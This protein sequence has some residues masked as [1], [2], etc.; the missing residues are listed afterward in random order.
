MAE[1]SEKRGEPDEAV[2][3]SY[4]AMKLS[5]YM[6]PLKS[7]VIIFITIINLSRNHSQLLLFWKGFTLGGSWEPFKESCGN[8][9]SIYKI[10]A[11]AH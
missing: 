9:A 2:N 10:C 11:Q 5:L 8:G 1:L 4:L 6:V 3:R 7:N